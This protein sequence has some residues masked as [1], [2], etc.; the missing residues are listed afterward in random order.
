MKTFRGLAIPE[1]NVHVCQAYEC[2]GLKCDS[3][4]LFGNKEVLKQYLTIKERK[5]KLKNINYE[6]K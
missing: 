3:E 4:C 1:G 5:E 6:I 2:S